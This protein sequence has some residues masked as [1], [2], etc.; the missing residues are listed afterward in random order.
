VLVPLG[1]AF[2]DDTFLVTAITFLDRKWPHLA[3][4]GQVLVRVH[5]GRIDDTRSSTMDDAALIA[6]VRAELAVL[7]RRWPRSG[8][9]VVVRWPRGLPQYRVGHL[10]LVG[11]ARA[12][13]ARLDLQLAGN[14]YDGVGVPASI[15]SGRAAARGAL[16][17]LDAP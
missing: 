16:A 7:L 14:A 13:A 17:V 5:V 10:A 2:G 8:D 6:R 4:A 15:A 3:R 9:A 12:A 11:A 1:T